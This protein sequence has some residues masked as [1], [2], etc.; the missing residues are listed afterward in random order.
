M[1]VL[2]TL[3][4]SAFALSPAQHAQPLEQAT[5]EQ[6]A[7]RLAPSPPLTRGLRNIVP[8]RRQ[9]DLVV[10]FEFDSD[11]LQPVSK[12]LLE[13][14]ALA[15]N[16]DRLQGLQFMVEGHTDAKGSARYNDQLSM[17]RARSVVQ[18]LQSQGV[19]AERLQAQGKGFS[20]PFIRDQPKAPENRRVRILTVVQ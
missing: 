18:F 12:P 3:A 1:T 9:I 14:L 6:L 16:S 19:P 5:A 15:M 13:S 8:E 11:R 4:A 7:E 20:E 2:A 10:R 17:R